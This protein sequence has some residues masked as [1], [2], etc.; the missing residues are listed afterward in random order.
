MET[1]L[2]ELRRNALDLVVGRLI[3]SD[4]AG[5]LADEALE[6]GSVVLIV[7]SKHPLVTK[8]K[9]V[10]WQDLADYP[11]VLPPVGSLQREPLER[12]LQQNGCSL[13]GNFIE[14]LSVHVVTGYLQ[15]THAIGSLS[16]VAAHH[17]IQT[18]VL[19]LLPLVLPDPQR[20]IGMMWSRHRP[21]SPAVNEFKNCL[22][23]AAVGY[24]AIRAGS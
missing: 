20:P 23:Q 21:A 6:P 13:P 12:A 22:R 14:T 9:S 10:R 15:A 18:G 17:Y 5:D 11:W 2:P 4:L 16:R 1:L 8:K 7:A 3:P 19:A 24:P